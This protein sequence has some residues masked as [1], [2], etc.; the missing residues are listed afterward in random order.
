M[1]RPSLLQR[2]LASTGRW[3]LGQGGGRPGASYYRGAY[4]G[5]L[6]D[7]FMPTA[8]AMD[9]LLKA[10]LGLLRE[11]S[12]QFAEDNPHAKGFLRD[13]RINVIGVED[14]GIPLQA[15]VTLP[16]GKR[17]A[18]DINARIEAAWKRWGMPETASANGQDSWADLQNLYLT[19]LAVD[20]EVLW[21]ERPG[22]DNPF[23]FEVE[24][25]DCALLDEKLNRP[26]GVGQNE[27]R[28]GVE[29]NE[30]GRP[31]AYWVWT[32]YP[33]EGRVRERVRLPAGE[34][35]HD[36]IRWR[37]GQTR[38]VPWFAPVLFDWKML[39]GYTEA[40]VVKARAEANSGG[41]FTA[42]GED[43]QM[44]ADKGPGSATDPSAAAGQEDRIVLE[45]EP[46]LYR[47]LPPG[48]SFQPIEPTSPNSNQPAFQKVMLQWIAR[49]LGPSY[50]SLSGDFENTNYSSGR[51]GL[52][53]ERDFYRSLA[54]WVTMR[55]HRPVKARWMLMSTLTGAL[56]L[57]TADVAAYSAD[58]WLYR[59][60]P[61]IDP[62]NDMQAAGLEVQM[63]LNSL[64]RL[65]AER[66][67]DFEE[68]L[69]ER[70]EELR[71]AE[72]YGVPL[73]EDVAVEQTKVAIDDPTK[74][75]QAP[76]QDEQDQKKTLRKPA[77]YSTA[78]RLLKAAAGV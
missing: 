51:M 21:R 62:L 45:S 67:R 44:W 7:D 49:G 50:T 78:L 54:R 39:D 18:R 12:R 48:L 2:M 14:G 1:S 20:G 10:D 63:G 41:F 33:G 74:Q 66:G 34:V 70:A 8:Q 28:L 77:G 37:V 26:R 38:G 6:T 13:L 76:T 5:R 23:G 72:E 17:M 32:A 42:T 15:R 31:V 68:I 29:L 36:F 24:F 46:G 52:L 59:G 71:L 57:P 3:L 73:G 27:I 69:Q 65:C 30:R 60:W 40:A 64:Q 58:R 55:F 75:G 56:E 11:R 35:H 4:T 9:R 43:A 19:M 47:Q 25:L 61:W 53:P 16:D 22:A